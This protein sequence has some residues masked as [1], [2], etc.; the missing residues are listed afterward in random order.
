MSS[1]DFSLNK[2]GWKAFEDLVA[3]ILREVWGQSFQTFAEG[4]DSGRDGAFYGAW[5]INGE[6]Y[7]GSFTVQCKF[8]SNV[9]NL[10]IS[11]VKSEFPKIAR[12]KENGFM[13]TVR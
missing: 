5:T 10:T 9:K 7:S 8:T 13:V 4:P 11:Q 6:K 12:L 1:I 3:C 2:L